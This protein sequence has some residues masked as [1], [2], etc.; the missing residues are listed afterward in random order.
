MVGTLKKLCCGFLV[1]CMFCLG[2]ASFQLDIPG[3]HL[4]C[5]EMFLAV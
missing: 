1:F 5:T 3:T 4:G 2:K